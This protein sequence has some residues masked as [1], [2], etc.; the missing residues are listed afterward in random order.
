MSRLRAI[1]NFIVG[2]AVAGGII[3]AATAINSSNQGDTPSSVASTNPTATMETNA[4]AP[5]GPAPVSSL[6]TLQ[7]LP[8]P[9]FDTACR[10]AHGLAYQATY[11]NDSNVGCSRGVT[12]A[13]IPLDEDNVCATSVGEGS[14]AVQPSVDT[15]WRC[16]DPGA[17]D[18]GPPN[19]ELLCRTLFGA[20]A[21]PALWAHDV[22]GWRCA[23]VQHGIF[24][25]LEFDFDAPCPATYGAETFA[26]QINTQTDGW[27]CY[28]VR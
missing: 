15:T 7:D 10:E 21:E 16:T 9:D 28:G 23:T 25:T 5:S 17:D 20:E 3:V 14:R 18:L 22:N 8:R 19:F 1:R 13:P 12:G 6:I 4:P 27:R 2:F 24:A 26:E 11:L